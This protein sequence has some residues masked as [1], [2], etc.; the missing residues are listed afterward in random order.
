MLYINEIEMP[1]HE[2]RHRVAPDCRVNY[3]DVRS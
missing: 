2:P 3:V 1:M